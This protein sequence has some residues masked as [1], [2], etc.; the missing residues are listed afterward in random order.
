[1]T[2]IDDPA[3]KVVRARTAMVQTARFYGALAL[4]LNPE[5]KAVETMATDGVHLFY[6][7]DW[8]EQQGMPEITGVCA[9]MVSHLALLHHTRRKHRDPALWKRA[10]D[11]AANPLVLEAGFTLP[12]GALVN[13]EYVGKSAEEIYHREKQQQDEQQKDEQSQDEQDEGEQSPQKSSPAAASSDEDS[14]P[15]EDASPT[16]QPSSAGA[17]GESGDPDPGN[18]GQ[19]LDAVNEDG[20]APSPTDIAQ[21]ESEQQL[22]VQQAK[23]M[24]QRAGQGSA[25]QQRL[26]D[27]LKRA[28]YDWREELKRFVLKRAKDTTSW[29]RPNRRLMAQGFRLPSLDSPK[30]GHMVLVVDVSASVIDWLE[31]FAAHLKTIWEDV[32]PQ[33]MTIIYCAATVTGIDEIGP[34]DE[35]A[36]RPR[37]TGGTDL[38]EAFKYLAESGEDEPDCCLV[39]TDME[40]PFPDRVPDYPVIWAATTEHQEPWGEVVRLKR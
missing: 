35:F 19:V 6:N 14:D 9:K 33:R 39:L 7:P 5:P 40:T 13:P 38:R 22:L 3:M 8:V 21:L 15:D 30:M 32:R 31:E 17:D 37:G 26:L 2:R 34:D 4:R 1:M 23:A 29:A 20:S 36:I 25:D 28:K 16:E 12:D 11:Y 24:A 10:C 18:A 27:N